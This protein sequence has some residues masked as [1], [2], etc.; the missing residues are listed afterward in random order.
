MRRASLA[1][2]LLTGC[3]QFHTGPIPGAPEDATFTDVEGARVR[4]VDE[5]EGPAVVMIHGFGSSLNVWDGVRP[6]LRDAHRVLAMDLKGFGWSD[7]PEGDYSPQA[8]AR[9][10]LALM[11]QRGIQEATVVAHSWGSSVALAL[12]LMAPERVRRIALYSAFVYRDQ[13]NTFAAWADADGMGEALFTMFYDQRPEE[14]VAQAFFDPDRV[15][16]AFYDAA[17]ESIERPGAAAAA[18]AVTRGMH[19]EEERY[20]EIE[21]P[22]LLL[23]G[24]ED[25]V[26]S[27]SAGER[28]YSQLAEADLRVFPRCGHFP[29]MEARRPST[30]ALRRFLAEERETVALRPPAPAPAPVPTTDPYVPPPAPPPLEPDEPD[31]AT[32][33][34]PAEEAP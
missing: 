34:V 5:G 25:R 24:R 21:Q 8:Q 18:L 29:M 7:R 11:D 26:A 3:V 6:A 12:T 1:A 15:P 13:R 30:R 14:R 9:L 17:A 19:F 2:L 33:P 23:W 22:V 20:E 16:E 28:L 27:L 4:F 32:D 31:V 10:V